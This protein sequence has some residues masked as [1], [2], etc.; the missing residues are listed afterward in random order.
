M[1]P[2]PSQTRP[3]M[4][5]MKRAMSLAPVKKTCTLA[6]SLV[7]QEFTI[8]SVTAWKVKKDKACQQ[9]YEIIG[10]LIFIIYM[11]YL[12]MLLESAKNWQFKIYVS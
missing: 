10:F 6:A 3:P 7:S 1:I 4:T 2:L 12:Y 11:I 5:M 8:A 9:L